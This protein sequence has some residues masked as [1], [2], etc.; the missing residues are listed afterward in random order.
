MKPCSCKIQLNQY[1]PVFQIALTLTMVVCYVDITYGC[2]L[3]KKCLCSDLP[4]SIQPETASAINRWVAH[5]SLQFGEQV[6]HCIRNFVSQL[7]DL[8][9]CSSVLDCFE[10]P[11]Q[12][13]GK[14]IAFEPSFVGHSICQNQVVHYSQPSFMRHKVQ[15]CQ[16]F[17]CIIA[18]RATLNSRTTIFPIFSY[19]KCLFSWPETATLYF[20]FWNT[21]ATAFTV[22]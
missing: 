1:W 7:E 19:L 8:N 11:F 14:K 15:P 22:G 16:S 10:E 2:V 9:S 4:S 18:K 12:F 6:C 21:A 20:C 3:R 17:N 5:F 13:G